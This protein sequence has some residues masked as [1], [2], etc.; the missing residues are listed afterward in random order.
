MVVRRKT[1][2]FLTRDCDV[3][4]VDSG[5]AH[6]HAHAHAHVSLPFG[7]G[8]GEIEREIERLWRPPK[9][10]DGEGDNLGRSRADDDAWARD[11]SYII[12][13]PPFSLSKPNTHNHKVVIV[14]A[15]STRKMLALLDE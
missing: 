4:L 8:C 10:W 5:H 14:G 13:P 6:A 9:R 2:F 7:L 11:L 1:H 15:V 3:D 12:N